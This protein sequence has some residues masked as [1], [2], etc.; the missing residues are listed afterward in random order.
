MSRRAGPGAVLPDWQ[1]HHPRDRAGRVA[2]QRHGQAA[3]NAA[4][5]V[6]LRHI[7]KH[8]KRHK[9]IP[10]GK[11]SLQTI[12]SFQNP[13]TWAGK[14]YFLMTNCFPNRKLKKKIYFAYL[15]ST[16]P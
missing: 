16:P 2:R 4:S 12:Y 9:T 8:S 10:K 14:T 15:K 3:G 7:C 1:L 5:T 6:L 13:N 11:H